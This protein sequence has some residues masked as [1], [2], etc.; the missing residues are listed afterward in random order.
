MSVVAMR[1][2]EPV[3]SALAKA[4]ADD[5]IPP[6]TLARQALVRELRRRGHLTDTATEAARG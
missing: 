3:R 1:L 6:A 2:T 4:A 5:A